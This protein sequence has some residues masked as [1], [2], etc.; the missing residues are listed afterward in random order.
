MVVYNFS[1]HISA[2]QKTDVFFLHCS[3]GN[4][5]AFKAKANGIFNDI[6]IQKYCCKQRKIVSC[7]YLNYELKV[8]IRM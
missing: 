5:S 2:L 7:V 3:L 6:I 1:A 8:K 4:H